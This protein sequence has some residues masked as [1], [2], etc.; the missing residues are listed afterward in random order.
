MANEAGKTAIQLLNTNKE[1][2]QRIAEPEEQE[3]MSLD[4]FY[5]NVDKPN[6]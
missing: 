2:V 3:V 4:D 6:T 1:Q 5:K